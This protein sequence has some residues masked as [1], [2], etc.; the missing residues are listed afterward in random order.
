MDAPFPPRSQP[1]APPRRQPNPPPVPVRVLTRIVAAGTVKRGNDHYLRATLAF[2]PEPVDV[3]SDA[4]KEDQKKS[5][6]QR[7][8]VDLTE[9]PRAIEERFPIEAN[10]TGLGED[11][12]HKASVVLNIAPVAR[13][14]DRILPLDAGTPTKWKRLIARR[15]D[16]I[17]DL[18]DLWRRL[19]APPD[20]IKDLEDNDKFAATYDSRR[21]LETHWLHYVEAGVAFADPWGQLCT[22]LR[23]SIVGSGVQKLIPENQ[24]RIAYVSS[25]PYADAANVLSAI[26]MQASMDTLWDRSRRPKREQLK[27]RSPTAGAMTKLGRLASGPDLV[28]E[29]P[30][31]MV[32]AAIDASARTSLV[33]PLAFKDFAGG[34]GFRSHRNQSVARN[35]EQKFSRRHGRDQAGDNDQPAGQQQVFSWRGKQRDGVRWRYTDAFGA[36]LKDDAIRQKFDE[37]VKSEGSKPQPSARELAGEAVEVLARREGDY[38]LLQHF[39]AMRTARYELTAAQKS[40]VAEAI[41]AQANA[42][43]AEPDPRRRER[44]RRVAQGKAEANWRKYDRVARQ[45]T[46][47]AGRRFFG[48]QAF[49]TLARLFNLVIDVEIKLFDI[50]KDV[51]E[52]TDPLRLDE[53]AVDFDV[54]EVDRP[55]SGPRTAE[56]IYLQLM[57]PPP[58]V[59]ADPAQAAAHAAQIVWSVVKLRQPGPSDDAHFWPVTFEEIEIAR[60]IVAAPSD[61]GLQKMRPPQ[62][63]GLVDLG[64]K[65]EDGKARFELDNLDF[66]QALEQYSNALE[67]TQAALEGGAPLDRAGEGLGTLRTGGLALLDRMRPDRV[68]KSAQDTREQVKQRADGGANVLDARGITVGYRADV[69]VRPRGER[70]DHRFV[71]RSLMN[72]IVRYEDPQDPT[73]G[74]IE[75]KQLERKLAELRLGV[76]DRIRLDSGSVRTPSK[77]IALDHNRDP[78]QA[79][80]IAS[81]DLFVWTGDPLGLEC[82]GASEQTSTVDVDPTRDLPLT[83]VYDLPRDSDVKR[84]RDPQRRDQEAFTPP[85]LEFGRGYR[86]GLRAVYLGGVTLPLER[87]AARYEKAKDGSLTLPRRD[88]NGHRFLRE[89]PIP[90]PLV[91]LTERV[92]P[93]TP[94]ATSPRH[95]DQPWDPADLVVVRTGEDPRLG[96]ETAWRVIVPPAVPME[97]AVLH[98]L[99]GWDRTVGDGGRQGKRLVDGMVNVDIDPNWGGFPH[100]D[101]TRRKVDYNPEKSDPNG[102]KTVHDAVFRVKATSDA[103]LATRKQ[104]YYPD[105]AARQLAVEVATRRPD[106]E[107]KEQPL[108][109]PLDDPENGVRYP[110]YVPVLL[111]VVA[112]KATEARRRIANFDSAIDVGVIAKGGKFEPRS[113]RGWQ[114]SDGTVRARRVVIRLRPG[115]DFDVRLW[116]PAHSEDLARWFQACE[117]SLQ[118]SHLVGV[119]DTQ[120]SPNSQLGTKAMRAAGL[121]LDERSGDATIM[122]GLLASMEEERAEAVIKELEAK[123]AHHAGSRL[124]AFANVT[125]PDEVSGGL[126]RLFA[127]KIGERLREIPAPGFAQARTIRV[128]HAVQ[129]PRF[130]PCFVGLEAAD[131]PNCTAT[132]DG[133]KLVAVVRKEFDETA[134]AATSP[135]QGAPAVNDEN[136]RSGWILAH[137]DPTNW[138]APD[139]RHE[140]G[141]ADTVLGG[142]VAVDLDTTS[143]LTLWATTAIV[144]DDVNR[145]RDRS[146]PLPKP[147]QKGHGREAVEPRDETLE[148]YGFSVDADGCVTFPLQRIELLR[149]RDLSAEIHAQKVEDLVEKPEVL[150]LLL[151]P[152]GAVREYERRYRFREPKAIKLDLEL[153]A[154]SRFEHMLLREPDP[155]P[156][157]GDKP[158]A[159]VKP[160]TRL[161]AK[162]TLW[163]PATKRPDPI[164]RKSLLPA[165]VWSEK[166]D[167]SEIERRMVVRIRMKRPWVSAG[168]GEKLGIV[169][170]PPEITDPSRRDE[171]ARDIARDIARSSRDKAVYREYEHFEDSDLGPGG[172][173]ITR[174]GTDAIRRGPVQTGFFMPLEAF[175]DVHPNGSNKC[176]AQLVP[177]ARMPIPRGDSEEVVPESRSRSMQLQNTMLVSLVA[178]EPRFDIIDE[179]WYVDAEISPLAL[180]YPFVRLGLVRYQECAPPEWQ[181]SEPI[182]EFIQLLPRRHVVINTEPPGKNGYPVRI[183]VYGPGSDLVEFQR[184]DERDAGAKVDALHRPV[185]KVTVLRAAPGAETYSGGARDPQIPEIIATAPDGRTLQEWNSG[186][187]PEVISARRGEQGLEWI[188]RFDLKDDPST[189]PHSVFLEEVDWMLPT[190]PIAEAKRQ[191][192]GKTSDPIITESGPRF[193]LKLRIRSS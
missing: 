39:W 191:A 32:R 75:Q 4:W 147:M 188:L 89:E 27:F 73:P 187:H 20:Q 36:F 106:A 104:P 172:Q 169:L 181:V 119:L 18:T 113:W 51:N 144:V 135:A 64:F 23:Q 176:K 186:D 98:R 90:P 114:Q 72:R 43:R 53:E 166:F 134:G 190:D 54:A 61:T 46:D 81:Q 94:S 107:R 116:C 68:V 180:A 165:F 24:Q 35:A 173:F 136:K 50:S 15:T 45:I 178:Y 185:L 95:P 175:R 170:W 148:I 182:V 100:L 152:G 3:S 25:V 12:Q 65:G 118:Y 47:A 139:I 30:A 93:P 66:T 145:V 143:Q 171:I 105:P 168:L 85:R 154:R 63:D 179:L 34:P 40:Q 131:P 126:F 124:P 158:P 160:L 1:A 37:V 137:P 16:A 7:E 69:G 133:E 52:L 76:E 183:E 71:W 142:R 130:A 70:P 97:F 28:P 59:A 57:H 6:P 96:P 13:E 174:W 2:L 92:L 19:L 88:S 33:S 77:L 79:E 67:G 42:Q 115:E 123:S 163:L 80:A 164:D 22:A 58:A 109:V 159:P 141:A 117:N 127:E 149:T 121:D 128:T 184:Q 83:I 108:I 60:D 49:P 138:P 48:L 140:E 17:S 38:A 157:R 91:T 74:R 10:V 103:D 29:G 14:G 129:V 112:L 26:R 99:R 78:K 120:L 56:A 111:E 156:Q 153:E 41:R 62:F 177:N 150:D 167:G 9:W 55:G 11:H 192:P 102:D 21:V 8:F 86:I 146:K 110:D 155:D 44:A 193:A 162:T 132:S 101:E 125:A 189:I 87:A 31:A 161:G 82:G 84:D 122:R 5:A 151:M